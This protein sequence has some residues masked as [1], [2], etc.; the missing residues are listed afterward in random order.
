MVGGGAR[1]FTPKSIANNTLWLQFGDEMY[2]DIAKTVPAVNAGDPVMVWGDKS[3]SGNDATR[4]GVDRP[5]A[6]ADGVDFVQASS[7]YLNL[8]STVLNGAEWTVII[9]AKKKAAGANMEFIGKIGGGSYFR[10]TATVTQII[11]YTN[12]GTQNDVM[13]VNGCP[14]DANYYTW[15]LRYQNTSKNIRR[16]GIQ[17]GEVLGLNNGPNLANKFEAIGRYNTGYANALFSDIIAYSRYITDA[18]CLLLEA[19]IPFT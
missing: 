15:I 14:N 19:A 17:V 9:R 10:Y 5:T 7:Q 6:G 8:V 16:N 1:V 4:N 12:D 18:E 2:Q 3:G 13:T 11:W